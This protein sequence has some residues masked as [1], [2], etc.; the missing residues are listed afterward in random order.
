MRSLISL[1]ILRRREDTDELIDHPIL[2]HL[3][4]W[5]FG[6]ENNSLWH[7]LTQLWVEDYSLRRPTQNEIN[8]GPPMKSL[9]L[10]KQSDI[11]LL[12]NEARFKNL[13]HLGGIDD[14][15]LFQRFDHLPNLKYIRGTTRDAQVYYWS[16]I[17]HEKSI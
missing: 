4:G 5:L 12:R 14:S 7:S 8:G 11:E 9:L 17:H 15:V 3:L 16:L 2:E 6:E 1:V 13:Q 10:P